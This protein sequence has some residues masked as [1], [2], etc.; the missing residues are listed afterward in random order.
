MKL[1]RIEKKIGTDNIIVNPSQICCIETDDGCVVLRMACGRGIQTKFTDVD[2]AVDYIQRSA[3]VAMTQ[4]ASYVRSY[5]QPN[6]VPYDTRIRCANCV[7]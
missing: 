2:H 5:W 3:F 4:Q 7:C 1:V 6:T